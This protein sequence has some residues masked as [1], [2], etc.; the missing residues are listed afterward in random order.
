MGD[1]EHGRTELLR[2]FPYLPADLFAQAGIEIA[3]RFVHQKQSWIDRN[4][5]GE[6][7]A[8]LLPAAEQRRG[9]L[10]E[11]LDL[12]QAQCLANPAI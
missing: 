10:G 2:E 4:G 8:L 3:Q 6:S 9:A 1:I 5:A 11:L 7:H 12:H